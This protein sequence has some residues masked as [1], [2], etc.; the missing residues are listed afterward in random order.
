M[1]TNKQIEN[2]EKIADLNDGHCP[3]CLQTIKFYHYKINKTHAQ[4]LRSMAEQIRVTGV[5]DVDISTI[6][7]AY[8]IRSQVTKMRQHGL[9]ARVKTN[10]G[11]QAAR[12]WLITKKGW[13]FLNGLP[14]DS[15]V[16]VFNN[17]VLGHTGGLITIHGVLGEIFN[18]ESPIYEETPVSVPEARTYSEVRSIKKLLNIQAKFKGRDY[19][20]RFKTGQIYSLTIKKLALGQPVEITS[21]DDQPSTRTYLDIAA[22][23]RDWGAL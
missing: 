15:K 10:Q 23:Q 3:E 13:S 20:G 11:T 1:L 16:I 12:H 9:I 21:I 17:Q 6:G 22:F 19:L 8:S 5:N 4:F 7:L 2:L 14:I 18:A